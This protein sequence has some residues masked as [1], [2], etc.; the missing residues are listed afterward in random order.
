MP[1][2]PIIDAHLHLWDPAHFRLAWLD[3]NPLLNQKYDLAK[4]TQATNEA[5]VR[6]EGMV[7][8]QTE[9]ETPYAFLEAAWAA[10]LAK[11]DPRL[12]A[13]VAWAPLEHGERARA[14][15]EALVNLSPLVKGIRRIIQ[16]EPDLNF[17]LQPDFV[18]G[19]QILPEYQLSFDICID[20]RHL[21][22]TLKFVNQCPNTSFILDHIGKPNIKARTLDPW[23][24]QLEELASFPNIFCKV[25]GLVVEADHRRWQPEDLAPFLSHVLATFGEDRVMFG[26]DWPVVLQAASYRRWVE[27]LDTLTGQLTPTVKKK[28][29]NANARRFYQLTC[30]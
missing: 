28:L 6:I 5:G 7:Y 25:S 18:R 19:V 12:Q 16:F 15:L 22:N 20:Y 26:G 27:T 11:A 8:L 1:D 3:D 29:C 24:K 2:F 9:V 10:T 17:C 30:S 23:R 13:I 4:Y 14:F 21:A